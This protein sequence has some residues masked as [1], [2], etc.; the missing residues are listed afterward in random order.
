M[1]ETGE[2]FYTIREKRLFRE[3]YASFEEYVRKK[4]KVPVEY[5]EIAIEFYLAS[6]N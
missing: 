3:E 4:W 1:T 5:A 6:R 2:A